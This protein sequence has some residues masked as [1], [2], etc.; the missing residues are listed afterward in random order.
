MYIF[1]IVYCNYITNYIINDHRQYVQEPLARQNSNRTVVVK[2][3][4][5][6]SFTYMV[7]LQQFNPVHDILQFAHFG[8]LLHIG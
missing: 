3:I 7:E 6:F 4:L 5:D 1:R 2:V 8:C